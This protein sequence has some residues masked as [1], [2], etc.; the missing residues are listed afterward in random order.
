MK[1]IYAFYVL[2]R[3]VILSDQY[4]CPE[5]SGQPALWSVNKNDTVCIKNHTRREKTQSG[6]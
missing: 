1:S 2:F 6:L 4:G 5:K 3:L